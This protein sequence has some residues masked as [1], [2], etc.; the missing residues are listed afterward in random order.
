MARFKPTNKTFNN[1][2]RCYKNNKNSAVL[3]KYIIKG[4]MVS[5]K[6]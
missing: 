2:T 3:N 1:R 5:H 6:I 4:K